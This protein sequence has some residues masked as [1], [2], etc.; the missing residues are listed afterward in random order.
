MVVGVLVLAGAIIAVLLISQQPNPTQN[1]EQI[2]EVVE[3]DTKKLTTDVSQLM[4]LP[5][6]TPVLM[7]VTDKTLLQDEIFKNAENGDRVMIYQ[8]AGVMVIYRER[9]NEIIA[10]GTVSTGSIEE[11]NIIPTGVAE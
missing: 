4:T 7:T 2:Q 8:E 1:S 11:S 10:S 3:E 9:T 5:D 6:E